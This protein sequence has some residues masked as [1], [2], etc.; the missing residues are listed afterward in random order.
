MRDKVLGVTRTNTKDGS[1]F[2]LFLKGQ[3]RSRVQVL[4]RTTQ[5][6]PY[7][8][9][10]VLSCFRAFHFISGLMS[11]LHLGEEAEL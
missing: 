7:R 4:F 3:D 11:L 1:D 2:P 5:R 9:Q 6:A 8:S 10:S